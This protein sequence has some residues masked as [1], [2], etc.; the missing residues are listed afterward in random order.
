MTTYQDIIAEKR[1]QNDKNKGNDNFAKA[2][3][4]ELSALG[5]PAILSS[6][7]EYTERVKVLNEVLSS[8]IKQ[9]KEGNVSTE[10][11]LQNVLDSVSRQYKDIVGQLVDMEKQEEIDLSPLL[12]E[13]NKL[14]SSI[15]VS[16]DK[17]INT[18]PLEISLQNS[19]KLYADSISASIDKLMEKHEDHKELEL[20]SYKPHDQKDDGDMQYFG[21]VNPEGAWYIIESDGS[22]FRYY[23][24]K[25]GYTTA[26]NGAATLQYKLLSEAVYEV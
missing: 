6:P 2:L 14:L 20:E 9:V 1:Q 22:K 21:F 26:F 24:G 5:S 4:R 19:L 3:A 10:K 16:S 23:F 13:T 18:R 8:A 15:K 25:D 17:T 7:D 11:T 12:K